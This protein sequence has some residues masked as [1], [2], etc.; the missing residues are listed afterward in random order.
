MAVA[1][2][3]TT[4]RTRR[5][6]LRNNAARLGAPA[7]PVIVVAGF[8]VT[9]L[10]DPETGRHVWGTA[11]A[12][13]QTRYPD[14]LDLPASGFDRLV[15]RGW[16]GSRGPVNTGWQIAIALRK[17]GGYTW[18]RDVHPFHYD[19]RLSARHNAQLLAKKVEELGGSVDIVT[20]S[21]G[22][23][24]ALTYV[25]LL[26]GAEHVEH[27]VM[28][29][30]VE[31]GVIEAFRIFVKPERFLRRS[32]TPAM[33]ATW[34]FLAELLPEDGRF[35]TDATLDFWTEDAWR[36]TV[37]VVPRN[38]AE[39][40]RLRDEL[41]AAPL[42]TKTTIIAGDCVPTATRMEWSTRTLTGF[43]PGD[44]T[45]PA[46]R[47]ARLFCDGHQGIAADPNV[48]RALVRTLRE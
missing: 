43:V 44:G 22:S 29:A 4:D 10:V 18:L 24:V 26:G 27:L 46:P 47:D 13:W 8:G 45:V 12:M 5:G 2:C 32:F 35:L 3:S 19:W 30:P 9:R 21:A 17:F 38:L 6:Y 34:P 16:V 7:R 39:A 1:H 42:H 36:S 28:I 37:G 14:D 48:H 31:Q 15:P 23:L 40:R 41:N 20:H 33:V 11:H 25:K